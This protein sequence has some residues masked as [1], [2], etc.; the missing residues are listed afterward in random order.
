MT[1]IEKCKICGEPTKV[2]FNINF[3]AIPIC[4]NCATRIFLQQAQWYTKFT[5]EEIFRK[6][7]ELKIRSKEV[8]MQS[9]PAINSKESWL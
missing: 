7:K 1:K 9:R 3:E 2:I 5:F 8:E 4:E 6:E